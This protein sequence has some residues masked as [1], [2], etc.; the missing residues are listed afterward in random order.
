MIKSTTSPARNVIERRLPRL[1]HPVSHR[2]RLPQTAVVPDK[3]TWWETGRLGHLSGS[4]WPLSDGGAIGA[5][6]FQ[7]AE[8]PKW[9]IKTR[10][11]FPHSRSLDA[12][13]PPAHPPS[14]LSPRY[15][16]AVPSSLCGSPGSPAFPSP[17][18]SMGTATADSGP[19]DPRRR[20]APQCGPPRT[21]I[22]RLVEAAAGC[23][24]RQPPCRPGRRRCG[25]PSQTTIAV[26]CNAL[27]ASMVAA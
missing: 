5:F 12:T 2:R 3:S 19:R 15:G 8:P 6:A 9:D 25:P 1:R 27:P 23:R 26:S 21:E 11:L 4:P 16:P 7:W 24:H 10:A 22:M 20:L 18:C 13:E 14:R 17:G